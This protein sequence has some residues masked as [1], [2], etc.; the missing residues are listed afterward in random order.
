[1]EYL[2]LL[3]SW[4]GSRLL[5]VMAGAEGQQ[6][7]IDV[8]PSARLIGFNTLVTFGAVILFGLV[9]ALSASRADVN[10]GMKQQRSRRLRLSPMLV[11]AQVALLLP[12]IAT[13][14]LL[15]QTLDNLRTRDLGFAA[16]ALVQIRTQPEASGY[17]REQLPQLARRIVERLRTT[18]GV[19]AASV[20]NSGFATGTSSTCCIGIPGRVFESANDRDVRMIGVGP[21][22]FAT[23]G[24][25]LRSRDFTT[26]D[27]SA[28][29][30][31]PGKVAIVNEAFVRQFFENGSPIG[32]HFGWGDPP[33]VK[34]HI[35]VV[36]VV[37]DAIC[38]EIRGVSRPLIYFPS[39]AGRVYVVRAAGM[40]ATSRAA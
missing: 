8:M 29:P 25:R 6:I 36:G 17:Q 1:M 20:A 11:V 32:K 4:W 2:G 27:V 40:P 39:E 33:T 34:D 35:E 22:Y 30:L 14:A 37:N 16:E 13:A 24:Q 9:P 10:G 5:L 23:A 28:N 38:D 18:P 19:R 21:G 15:L 26:Q 31:G 7:H 12:L 3:L